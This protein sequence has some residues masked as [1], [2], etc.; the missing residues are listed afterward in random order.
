MKIVV[1]I[2]IILMR[3]RSPCRVNDSLYWS[4]MWNL[5]HLW[6]TQ[7]RTLLAVLKA[8][9]NYLWLY[10][11]KQS[12]RWTFLRQTIYRIRPLACS[13]KSR[14]SASQK[15]SSS[16]ARSDICIILLMHFWPTIKMQVFTDFLI[17]CEL[18]LFMS[19]HLYTFYS[20]SK[21][22]NAAN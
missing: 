17:G 22:T 2:F 18:K 6:Y 10:R 13:P 16:G 7:T 3:L 19:R 4:F 9:S 8:F 12:A 21:D 11:T 20:K 5:R 15:A 14:W 1:N